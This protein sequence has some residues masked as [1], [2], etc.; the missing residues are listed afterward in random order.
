MKRVLITAPYLQPVLSEYQPML[1][2]HGV[3]VV[4]PPV[5]QLL[6]EDEMVR[7]IKGCEGIICGD[8][9][10]TGRVMDAAPLRVICKWGTGIDNIDQ[11]AAKARGIPVRNT[12]NAFTEPVADT[13]LAFML[14]FARQVPW[15]HSA[16]VNGRWEKR[17]AVCLSERTLGVFGM[18]N[19]GRAVVRRARAFGM[20]VLWT[21]VVDAKPP[22]A[23][24]PGVR[25]VDRDVLIRES[26]FIS[27]NCNYSPANRH[28]I[29]EREIA[30][31]R[32][33][34]V[35][36]NT[37]RGPLVD[38]R[39]LA[40]ALAEGRIAGAGLDVFEVE[41]LPADSPLRRLPNVLLAPH[42]A[43]ASP[44]YWRKVHENSIRNLLDGLGLRAPE[45]KP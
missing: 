5:H 18:G 15:M 25:I 38:E 3:E 31:M 45:A 9:P 8:D 6:S 20:P 42:N 27:L 43:N 7:W 24:D 44:G 39:A 37:A 28:M 21:D 22:E 41:P 34:A 2:A 1:A 16:M 17:P 32:P 19:I 4:A 26:D 33:T 30:S 12:P 10:V 40:A 36:I 14:A 29:G 35:L 13:V 11:A 23:A